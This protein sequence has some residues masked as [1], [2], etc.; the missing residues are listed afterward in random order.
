[1]TPARY[2]PFA[3]ALLA[4]LVP[5]LALLGAAG[6]DRA[7]DGLAVSPFGWPRVIVI[8]L[9]ATLPLS[10]V[11][12][13]RLPAGRGWAIAAAG[14]G[15]LLALATFAAGPL[16]GA[17][18]DMAEAG[19]AGRFVARG[20]WCLALQMP[21]CLAGLALAAR[22]PRPVPAAAWLLAAL[23]AIAPP[24]VYAAT[25]A[26]NWARQAATAL[27]DGRLRRAEIILTGLADLGRDT[28]VN[29]ARAQVART[30]RSVRAAVERPLPPDAPPTARLEYARNL[31][32]LDRLAEAADLLAPLTGQ[33]A[34]AA[35]LRA[36][37]LQKLTR[38][39]ES[40]RDYRAALALLADNDRTAPP[41]VEAYEGLAFN[42][43]AAGRPADAE[44]AY[45]EALARVPA[46]GAYLHL[47]LARH[48]KAG[49]RPNR[50]IEH[51]QEAVRLD[52]SLADQARPLV[53]DM[54]TATPGCLLRRPGETTRELP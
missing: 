53:N 40:D 1:M 31:A 21:W 43:R 29:G 27:D 5:G 38:Y 8:H 46:A 39:D 20:L 11:L 26:E 23:A 28:P 4:L 17:W 47:Q 42:A 13:G 3:G 14:L 7:A 50:A 36:T 6:P 15:A 16:V 41:R 52:P 12:A 18:L 48:Y 34:D 25:A 22:P 19:R 35:L 24:A 32:V 44:A 54:T 45:R 30:L 2:A 37:A 9:I 33:S 49:G 51:L 10:L